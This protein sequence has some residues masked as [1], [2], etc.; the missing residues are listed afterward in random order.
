[1]AET[2]LCCVNSANYNLYALG[3]NSEVSIFNITFQHF[4]PA[5]LTFMSQ[6]PVWTILKAWSGERKRIK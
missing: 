3:L 5:P 6:R 2:C 1:M 4:P